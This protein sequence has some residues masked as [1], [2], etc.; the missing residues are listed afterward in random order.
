MFLTDLSRPT[1]T[2][3]AVGTGALSI[4]IGV[5]TV[6]SSLPPGTLQQAFNFKEN[7]V[8]AILA[9]AAIIVALG[10]LVKAGAGRS[11][12]PQIDGV[13]SVEIP[14]G[15]TVHVATPNVQV[16]PTTPNAS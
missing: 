12:V 1:G 10:S 8:A 5:S 9:I 3:A 11:F 15:S 2:V 7:P 6:I 4:V 14:V 16:P 13:T